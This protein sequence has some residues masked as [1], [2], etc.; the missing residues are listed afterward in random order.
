MTEHFA[1]NVL[2]TIRYLTGVQKIQ[3]ARPAIKKIS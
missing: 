3:E 1:E 2:V